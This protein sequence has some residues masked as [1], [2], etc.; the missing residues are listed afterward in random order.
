MTILENGDLIKLIQRRT[1]V[2]R[3]GVEN[4]ASLPRSLTQ[5]HIKNEAQFPLNRFDFNGKISM[6]FHF[7]FPPPTNPS[8]LM[9]NDETFINFL[10]QVI[11]ILYSLI[12]KGARFFRLFIFEETK[13]ERIIS[14]QKK[15]R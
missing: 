2:G 5:C 6:A 4:R 8:D 13:S 12:I 15:N 7:L 10:Y 14:V 3:W 9:S 1:A 11:E